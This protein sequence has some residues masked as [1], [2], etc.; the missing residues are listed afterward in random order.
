MTTS[1][2]PRPAKARTGNRG[3]NRR[4]ALLEAA[5]SLFGTK[6]Y[7]GTSI[8][9]ISSAVGMLPGSI[10]YHF[11]SKEDLLLAVH[12][13][14]VNS[15]LR[16]V[17]EAIGKVPEDDAWARLEAA[18]VA[19]LESLLGENSF[20]QVVTP[21]F[22]RSL[23]EPLRSSLIAQRDRYEKLFVEL[24]DTLDVPEGI[25]KRHLRLALLGSLNWSTT[26]YRKGRN[27]PATIARRM[28]DL[29]RYPLDTSTVS[30]GR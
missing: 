30:P 19:H 17:Q 22:T 12:E 21:Q 18:C 20:S 28:V 13:Q 3:E 16:A 4:E 24:V 8:R 6:G 26:W 7:D 29:Y 15:V 9:E 25:S 11:P 27:T 1:R 2:K 14:G 23:E 5:A 10:Y